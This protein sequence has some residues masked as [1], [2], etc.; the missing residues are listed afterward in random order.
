[1]S[2]L[3]EKAALLLRCSFAPVTSKATATNYVGRDR[4]AI[5]WTPISKLSSVRRG[6]IRRQLSRTPSKN[7]PCFFHF[8]TDIGKWACLSNRLLWNACAF[9]DHAC[10]RLYVW[11][12]SFGTRKTMVFSFLM[13]TLTRCLSGKHKRRRGANSPLP[14]PLSSFSVAHFLS[15][16]R[17]LCPPQNVCTSKSELSETS[18]I[19]QIDLTEKRV[20]WKGRENVR[21]LGQTLGQ[22]RF[23]TGPGMIGSVFSQQDRA[24]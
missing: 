5:S 14:S 17:P 9:F 23:S 8:G 20:Q 13:E 11:G 2:R 10:K 15:S 24:V 12:Y 4:S 16:F 3:G 22:D 21:K 6:E 1:M 7:N 19:H 18:I